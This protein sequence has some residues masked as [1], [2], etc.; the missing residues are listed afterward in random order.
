MNN[1]ANDKPNRQCP[2]YK[3]IPNT[4]FTVDAFSYGTVP[5]IT[6]YFLSHF[7][8]DHYG[9]MTKSWNHPVICSPITAKL[10][11]LKIKTNS[12]FIKILH[13]NEPEVIEK[14]EVTLLDANHCP[15]SV[16]FLFKLPNN[17]KVILHT[18]DFRAD[19]SMEEYPALWNNK[20]DQLYLDTTY[21]KAEYD[22]P[23]QSSVI[24]CSVDLMKKHLQKY[25]KTLICVGSYTIG[26]ERIFLA[27][28]NEIDA[29]IWGSTEKCRVLK[30]LSDPIIESRLINDPNKAQIHV[31]EMIKVKR[32]DLLQ[33]HLNKF[34]NYQTILGIGMVFNKTSILNSNNSNH[35]HIKD[36]EQKTTVIPETF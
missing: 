32:K 13:L 19:A 5:N 7:H 1:N 2:F 16:M 26:K 15:G 21:C 8:Y 25:P 30:T 33:E 3:K 10:I 24:N 9:G 6:H 12:K 34:S 14:T 11:F 36:F 35:K 17:G 20:I 23:N 31:V 27:I 28:A 18:G 4:T 22:F 29:K